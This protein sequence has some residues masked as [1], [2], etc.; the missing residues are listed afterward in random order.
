MSI[1]RYQVGPR[2][3]Q[4]VKHGNTIYVAGQVADDTSAGAKGQT[5]QILRKIDAALKHFGSDKSKLLS[6]TVYLASMSSFDE[7]N[8]AWE[9]WV[10]KANTPARA[11]VETRLARPA[12]VVEI[13]AIAST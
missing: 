8:A 11:T 3:S 12:Y 7:M 10:D 9:A 13:A 4:A 6:A 5:E 1:E 2:L